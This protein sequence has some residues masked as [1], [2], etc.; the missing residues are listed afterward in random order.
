[1]W[2]PPGLKKFLRELSAWRAFSFGRKNIALPLESMAMMVNT[3]STHL[4]V[5]EAITALLIIG[6]TG[7]SAILLPSFVRSPS[8]FN[9]ASAYSYSKARINV[10]AGGG[11]IKSKWIRS[12]IPNDL[13]IRT[14]V[15]RLLLYISGTVVS[16]SSCWNDQA[17]YSLKHLP[18]ATRPARPA[19]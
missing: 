2:S 17:V 13:S 8:S 9:A 19:L 11:S 15:P 16:S 14:T 18:G 12:S 1:M 10:S 5:S 3:W 6:S 4:K 7:N